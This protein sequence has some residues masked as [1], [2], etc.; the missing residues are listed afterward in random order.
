MV[1]IT[2]LGNPDSIRRRI[3]SL[4]VEVE[5][6]NIINPMDSHLRELYA[7]TY[8]EL[9]KQ[10]GVSMEVAHDVVADNSYFGTLMVYHGHA[11]GMVSGAMHTTS[12]TIRPAFEIIR[13]KPGA[14]IVSSVF[15]MCLADRCSYS[16]IA[17]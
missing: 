6:I 9:R 8:Y 7:H 17:P 1:N 2:L 15:F 5:G 13:T 10:K 4:G 14:S 16:E 12:H 11:D 3:S